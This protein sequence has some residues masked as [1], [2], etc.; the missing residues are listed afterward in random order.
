MSFK[1]LDKG[2][3]GAGGA[4]VGS[5]GADA[6]GKSSSS[7]SPSGTAGC[8]SN[9]TT[10]LDLPGMLWFM[11]ARSQA[12]TRLPLSWCLC[13]LFPL[14]LLTAPRK[15]S[16]KVSSPPPSRV[17]LGD[18]E[19]R[20]RMCLGNIRHGLCRTVLTPSKDAIV[21]VKDT[22]SVVLWSTPHTIV[23]LTPRTFIQLTPSMS[24]V[25][26]HWTSSVALGDSCR[27]RDIMTQG[28]INLQAEVSPETQD[29]N[30]K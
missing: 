20:V 21:P 14:V 13:L 5:E 23:R 9:T 30:R 1:K 11:A 16:L 8:H 3:G 2:G 15:E 29:P 4:G 18:R 10:V 17:G 22:L 26:L 24:G 19:Q 28:K 6:G 7:Q 12:L 27:R 25:C